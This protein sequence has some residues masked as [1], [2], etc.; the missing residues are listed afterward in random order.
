MSETKTFLEKIRIENFRSLQNVTLPLKPLTVLVG[1]NASG[2]SSVLDA[3]NLF[4][5]MMIVENP[6][7]PEFIQDLLWVG[8]ADNI[9]FQLHAKVKE[10]PA[11]YELNLEAAADNPF[12]AEELLVNNVE[13]VKVISV[14]K[15]QGI[16]QDED[17]K[18][19]TK[20]NSNKLALRSAGDY[21]NK[22]VTSALTEFVKSWKTYEFA[23]SLVRGGIR[24]FSPATTGIS[25][26]P[27][28]DSYGRQLADVLWDWA[29]NTPEDFQNVSESLAA[30]TKREIALRT[31]DG[32]NQLCL[33]EG[34]E[35]PV[36][37]KWASDG[38]LRLV[39]YYI[40]P[41]QIKL[42]SLIAIEEPEQGLHPGVLSD[43]A[44]ML[45]QTAER[46]QVIITTHSSQLLDAF[47]PENLSSSLGVLLLNNPPGQGTEVLNIEHIRQK[48]E[49]LDHWIADFGIGSA[50]FDSQLLQDL[51][52]EST[53]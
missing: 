14:Q 8:G 33:L 31:V 37:L 34:Y 43:L 11:L 16:V 47:K 48:R 41:N 5:R 2:K 9:T 38:T 40:L 13:N 17:G 7:P 6:P 28:L 35:N 27:E 44:K 1:P 25:E 22:P 36:P 49:A 52:E 26:S 4:N 53:C 15:G 20:Y 23:L 30:S 29:T 10:T 51:M 12:I 32:D 18:N 39:A 42:P 19:K 50:I 45:E 24:T 21:G 3:L 46:T